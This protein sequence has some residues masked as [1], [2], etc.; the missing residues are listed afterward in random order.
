VRGIYIINQG[1]V[2]N[3]I[4]LFLLAA[5]CLG[6]AIFGNDMIKAYIADPTNAM[7]VQVFIGILG[8]VAALLGVKWGRDK[9]R[10]ELKKEKPQVTKD[11]ISIQGG[12]HQIGD[13]NDMNI[14]HRTNIHIGEGRSSKDD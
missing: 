5:L 4:V 11:G 8:V 6:A 1:G 13:D 7:L 3:P 2:V 12:V 14:G 9:K 10:E